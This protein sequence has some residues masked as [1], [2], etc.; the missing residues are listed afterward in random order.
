MRIYFPVNIDEPR[1]QKTIHQPAIN[2]I[3][4]ECRDFQKNVQML[5]FCNF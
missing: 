5:K 1:S 3:S 4:G 2:M